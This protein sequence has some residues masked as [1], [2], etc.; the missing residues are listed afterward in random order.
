[1]LKTEIQRFRQQYSAVP[2]FHLSRQPWAAPHSWH[3][4]LQFDNVAA[5]IRLAIA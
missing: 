4:M 3:G 2:R 1:M 5:I